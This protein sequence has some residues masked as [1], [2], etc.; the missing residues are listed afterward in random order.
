M[1]SLHTTYRPQT[2]DEVIG[3]KNTVNKLDALLGRKE[4]P[5]HTFLLHGPRGCGKTTLGRIIP[6]TMGVLPE[7]I[8]EMNTSDYRRLADARD[9]IRQMQF[10]SFTGGNRF[11]LLDEA[12][13]L[14]T[15]A[16]D[17]LLKALEEPPPHVY[18][19]LCTTDPQKLKTTVKNRCHSLKVEPVS[20]NEMSSFLEE[21]AEA[22]GFELV[23][24]VK[25]AIVKKS[26]GTPRTALVLLDSVKDLGQE[27]MLDAVEGADDLEIELIELCRALFKGKSE[28]EVL[29]ILA[30]NKDQDPESIRRLVL[31][32]CGSI[33]LGKS[34]QATKEKAYLIMTAFEKPTYDTGFPG[35]VKCVYEAFLAIK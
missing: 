16:Q 22:E 32:Y 27:A 18:I 28:N 2:L 10:K 14:A 13:Q 34:N 3:N 26:E 35:V 30:A 25:E 7:D 4:G 31:G 23:A 9:L 29:G 8:C 20:D 24:A 11:F 17:C 19:C 12:H 15:A 21:V 6:K 33:I 5:P 1:P